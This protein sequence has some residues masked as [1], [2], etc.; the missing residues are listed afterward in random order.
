[1][2]NF[3]IS[4]KYFLEGIELYSNQNYNEAKL[5]FEESLKL[6]PNR[7]SILLNLSKTYF[8][9]HDYEKAEEKLEKLFLLVG[10]K[11]EKKEAF[12]LILEIY[13]KQNNINKIVLNKNRISISNLDNKFNYLKH[14]LF[15]P[16]FFN[17]NE[18][19]D[20]ARDNINENINHLL[21]SKDCPKLNLENEMLDP[22]NFWL[23]YD[24]KPNIDIYKKLVKLY[25][26]IY[27]INDEQNLDTNKSKNKIRIA[28]ISEFFTNHTIMKWFKGIIYKLDKQKF[29]VIVFHSDKT[30]K[31]NRFEEIKRNELIFKYENIF[32]PESFFEKKKI[33]QDKNLDI[34]FYTDIHMSTNLY[35][36]TLYKLARYQVTTLGHPETTG[37]KEIDYFLSSKLL[38]TDN[39]EKRYT[40]KVM[41]SESLPLYFYKPE[42][43]SKL[44]K[45]ELTEKNIYSCPQAIFKMHPNF[46]LAIKKILHRDKKAKI[47]FV[48]DKSEILY[49]QFINR[50]KKSIL[51]DFDR[52]KFIKPNNVEEFINH[53]GRASVLLDPFIF[54]SATS[55][56]ES[57]FYGTPTISMPTENMKSRIVTGAYKQ[58]KINDAPIK[59]N[60]DDYVDHAIEIAN[61]NNYDLKKFFRGQADKFIFNNDNFIKEFE[62]LFLEI[63]N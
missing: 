5:K 16:S 9:L 53:C 15:Y 27:Q 20:I 31:G 62:N 19:I 23:T 55:F 60:I 34:L 2:N 26:K 29:E 48:K 30:K 45:N 42:I 52:I 63:V 10:F 56:I 54:G 24:G 1:M 6:E 43:K 58:M 50:L 13:T 32:L 51:S 22:V 39:Y 3:E 37:N 38:E 35:F 21:N 28:F 57:M 40:E 14:S 17:S 47:Y 8:K 33:I 4:K 36:L 12:K 61:S 7:P 25:K 44:D 11:E 46:D 59:T 49:K 41:L 18:E